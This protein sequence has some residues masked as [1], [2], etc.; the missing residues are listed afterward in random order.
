MSKVAILNLLRQCVV[1]ATTTYSVRIE[2]R[3]CSGHVDYDHLHYVDANMLLVAIDRQIAS[4]DK[5]QTK[6]I[7]L[8]MH[9]WDKLLA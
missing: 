7:G 3:D 1:E 4:A 6:S 9:E 8:D 2:Y 5:E